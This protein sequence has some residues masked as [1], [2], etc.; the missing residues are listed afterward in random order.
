MSSPET[1]AAASGSKRIKVENA[2]DDQDVVV[3]D[4]RSGASDPPPNKNSAEPVD[5]DAEPQLLQDDSGGLE[6]FPGAPCVT[7]AMRCKRQNDSSPMYLNRYGPRRCCWFVR[8]TDLKG[9][10]DVE[11]LQD[12]AYNYERVLDYP[13]RKGEPRIGASSV[14][15]IIT[16]VWDCQG[17]EDD[18]LQ[19]AELLNPKKVK[20][21]DTLSTPKTRQDWLKLPGHK[22]ERYRATHVE[23]KFNQTMEN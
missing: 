22:L 1:D 14:Q 21:A 5:D 3:I 8:I 15:G 18:P 2:G 6:L 16:I 20:Q 11:K 19:A 10:V 9:S 13:R 12:V 17:F 7:V 23:V 4:Q